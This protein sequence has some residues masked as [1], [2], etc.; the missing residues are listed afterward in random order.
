MTLAGQVL[1]ALLLLAVLVRLAPG[2]MP[3]ALPFDAPVCHASDATDPAPVP[4]KAHECALCPVCLTTMVHAVLLGGPHP[5]A[6]EDT[7]RA[8]AWSRPQATAPP[9]ARLVVPPPRGPP[10]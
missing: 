4:G 8:A 3:V 7:A 1:R 10:A 6:P 2:P 5:P 9:S